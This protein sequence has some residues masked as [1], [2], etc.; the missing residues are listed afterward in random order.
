MWRLDGKR[1]LVTG[2]TRG[3]GAAVVAQ[4]RALG[5]QVITVA[6]R[7]ADVCADVTVAGDRARVVAAVGDAP[8]DVLVHDAGGNKRG[9]LVSYDDATIE[10]MIALNLTAP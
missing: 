4:L 1:A 6:R 9:P 10:A 3:I 7:D 8:L 5:A 2:G